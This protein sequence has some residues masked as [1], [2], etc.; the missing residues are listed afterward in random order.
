MIKTSINLQDLRR[1]IYLKAKADKSWR[2]LPDFDWIR[3]SRAC[4]SGGLL[5]LS[6][7]LLCTESTPSPIGLIT[8]GVKPAGKRSAVNLPAPFDVAGDGN[9]V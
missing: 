3:W 4:L 2:V 5:L 7:L 8:L 6:P 9:L 1:R